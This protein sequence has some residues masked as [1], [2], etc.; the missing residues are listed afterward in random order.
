VPTRTVRNADRR[1][2]EFAEGTI[3]LRSLGDIFCADGETAI[4]VRVAVNQKLRRDQH[5]ANAFW[6]ADAK[7][8]MRGKFTFLHVALQNR[9]TGDRENV[10]FTLDAP[11]Q[12]LAQEGQEEFSN[13]VD[14]LGISLPEDADQLRG[15]AGTF[16]WQ[17]GVRHFK[18]WPA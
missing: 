16:E 11:T 6:V 9:K 17:G 15:H 5:E 8:S 12:S 10:A 2:I 18:R 13:F 3:P 4:L 14:A 1:R 7:L